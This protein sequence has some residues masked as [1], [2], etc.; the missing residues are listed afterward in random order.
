[1]QNRYWMNGTKVTFIPEGEDQVSP[2]RNHPHPVIEPED[3]EKHIIKPWKDAAIKAMR[4]AYDE[5][6][7][8]TRDLYDEDAASDNDDGCDDSESNESDGG[9]TDEDEYT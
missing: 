7:D 9:M 5:A 1:M 3:I 6:R 8:V 2:Y 4:D